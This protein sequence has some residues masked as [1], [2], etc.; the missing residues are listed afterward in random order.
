MSEIAVDI[1][2]AIQPNPGGQLDFANDWDHFIIGLEGGWMSGKTYI[3]SRKLLT[4][5]MINAVTDDGEPTGVPSMVIAPTFSNVMDFDV[6]NLMDACKEAGLSAVWKGSGPLGNGRL[7]GPAIVLPDLG[8][9]SNP[10][11]ILIRSADKPSRITGIELG[12]ALGDEPARWKHDR[13]NP[14]GDPIVQLLGRIRHPL[15]RLLMALFVYTNEG[16]ATGIYD[17]MHSG[18][19]DCALYRASSTEN[20]K[21]KDFVERQTKFL[22]KELANQY[23]KGEAAC[24]RGGKVYPSFDDKMH[25]DSNVKMNPD[26]PPQVSLDFNIM[27]GMHAEIGQYHEDV[28][29]FTTVHEIHGSRMTVKETARKIVEY[30]RDVKWDFTKSG[31]LEVFGDATGKSEWSGTGQSNYDVLTEM[32]K[33][34]GLP[35]RLRLTAANPLVIDRV[36]AF[37]MALQDA[38]G[39]AHY[40]VHPS[41][42]RLIE[43]LRKLMLNQYGE[44]DKKDSKLSHPS[45]ADGYRVHY[46]RPIRREVATVGGRISV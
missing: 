16:D 11:A 31:P 34:E 25:V 43:D 22:T 6:P 44:V 20:P 18:K 5:H 21:A 39:N 30:F 28:D 36:H 46:L 12:S 14:L 10:S 38:Q 26:R 4:L 19:E 45:D 9:R 7:S 27:P 24:F 15:A 42:V 1:S 37:N 33:A 41:C 29:L 17:L 2:G 35:H 32:F 23:I 8:T 40:K 13:N 3:G